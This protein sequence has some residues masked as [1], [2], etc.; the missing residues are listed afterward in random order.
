MGGIYSMAVLSSDPL[1]IGKEL[2]PVLA[3]PA[4]LS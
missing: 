3:V 1:T 2:R 4:L